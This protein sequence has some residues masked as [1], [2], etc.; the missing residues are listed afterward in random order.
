[1]ADSKVTIDD[2]AASLISMGDRFEAQWKAQNW[3]IDVN[4]HKS[5]TWQAHSTSINELKQEI[6]SASD[7]ILSMKNRKMSEFE[8]KY[9]YRLKIRA[10]DLSFVNMAS[11]VDAMFGSALEIVN[12]VFRNI[13]PLSAPPKVDWEDLKKDRELLPKDL[14][15]RLR[16]I[17]ARLQ[18]LEPRSALIEKQIS[19]I[20]MAHQAAEQLPTDLADLA[21][22]RDDMQRLAAEA[23][24]LSEAIMAAHTRA[25]DGQHRIESIESNGLSR[26]DKAIIEAER[27][28]QRSEQAL[29][30]S[31]SAG[32]ARAFAERSQ[33]LG[34]TGAFW[35]GCLAL[36]LLVVL[37]VGGY[38]LHELKYV[39][40][41]TKS[42]SVIW[43]NI[44]LTALGVGAPVWFAWLATRQIGTTFKL[45]E[46]YAFKASVSQAYEGYRA[47]AVEIDPLL[48]E[49][50]FSSALTRIEEAPIRLVDDDLH[51][52]PLSEILSNPAIRKS[53][54]TIPGISEKI[55]ALIP[56]KFGSATAAIAPLATTAKAVQV[57]ALESDGEQTK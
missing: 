42:S 55:M 32:L 47:E 3:A 10:D 4:A 45:A 36:S 38:R 18:D 16:S 31:T 26:I 49:R 41:G 53:L 23:V 8:S 27:M 33:R 52:S 6:K 29:R 40:D 24:R 14:V 46:D 22:Q 21:S 56:S 7:R 15:R 48:R 51:N 25:E 5:V 17:E 12:S 50:L 30:G 28:I 1:M 37:L 2:V 13:A 43:A 54:E 44:I 9:T 39:L 35:T 11:D 19:D 34:R 20:E 57:I